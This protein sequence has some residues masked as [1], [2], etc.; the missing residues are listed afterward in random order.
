VAVLA[1]FFGDLPFVAQEN[2]SWA[3]SGTLFG[4]LQS[5]TLA[6]LRPCLK[7]KTLGVLAIRKPVLLFASLGLFLLR[8]AELS[9]A[10]QLFNLRNKPLNDL[11]SIL[12]HLW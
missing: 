1:V 12:N 7:T 8:L 2:T 10:R 11:M 5:K 3:P 9:T 4:S 6:T